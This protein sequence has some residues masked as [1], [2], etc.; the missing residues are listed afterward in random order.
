MKIFI[1]TRGRLDRQITYDR[2]SPEMRAV[3]WLV[4]PPDE[5]EGHERARRQVIARPVSGIANVRQW[6]VENCGQSVVIML[7]DDLTFYTWQREDKHQLARCTDAQVSKLINDLHA[8][9]D[10]NNSAHTGVAYR[11]N[12][13]NTWPKEFLFNHRM[14]AV[15]VLSS[16]IL[17]HHDLKYNDSELPLMEEYHLTLRLFELGYGNV[18]FNRTVWNQTSAFHGGMTGLRNEELQ[19]HASNTLASL[20]PDFVTVVKKEPKVGWADLR[21]R[22]D[23]RIQWKEAFKAGVRQYGER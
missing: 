16:T 9:V 17:E 19:A 15:H 13:N 6:I 22:T 14:N 10:Q 5:V 8:V 20:H 21:E 2:L 23:V 3:T 7:D 11:Q 1:P 4:A 18:I 12:N